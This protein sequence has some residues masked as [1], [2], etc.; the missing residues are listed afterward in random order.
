[1]F[2]EGTTER[3]IECAIAVHRSLGPGLLE[4]AYEATLE[5]EFRATGV[6]FRRQH[7]LAVTHRGQVVGEYR[8]DF[9]VEDSVVVELKS[10]E[11]LDPVFTAQILTYLR[12]S[13]KKVGLLFN[14]NSVL[15]TQGLR[16]FVL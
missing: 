8:L 11:R 1:M 16:R 10:V 2:L 3:I 15:L 14:F 13:G 6:P 7:P 5:I 4:A 9:L 12:A